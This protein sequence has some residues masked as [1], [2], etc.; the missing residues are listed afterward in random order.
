[1]KK[2]W[3]IIAN[4]TSIFPKIPLPNAYHSK[5]IYDK[6]PCLSYGFALRA[7]P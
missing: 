3:L 7:K 2:Q 4:Y 6:N 1:M 5:S